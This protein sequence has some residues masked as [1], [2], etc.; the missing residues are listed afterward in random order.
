MGLVKS[1][2]LLVFALVAARPEV[3]ERATRPVLQGLGDGTLTIMAVPENVP[4]EFYTVQCISAESDQVS[5]SVKRSGEDA[6]PPNAV[7]GELYQEVERGVFFRIEEGNETFAIGDT[8]S[9]VTYP[10]MEELDKLFDRWVSRYVKWIISREEKDRFEEL[11]APEDKLGFMESFWRRRDMSPEP[12]RMKRERSTSDGLHTQPNTS[13]PALRDGRPIWARST[14]CW[15]LPT[16]SIETP[17]VAPHSSV[18]LR[19]GPTTTH[20]TQ[21]YPLRSI[22]DSW[23]S[24]QRVATRSWTPRTSTSWRRFAR[25][26]DG[27]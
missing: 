11:G 13:G 16:P 6:V 20:R 8:F 3:T 25:T 23:T 21:G 4:L 17:P 10:D 22:S 27:P 2:L 26:S 9:F 24:P 7:A 12:R 18:L 15:G 5:F 1:F 14:S 19:Y